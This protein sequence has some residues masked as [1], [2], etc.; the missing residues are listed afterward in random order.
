MSFTDIQNKIANA[1]PLDFGNLLN[2]SIEL[3]KKV[4]LQGLLMLLIMFAFIIPFVFIIYIPLLIFG[5]IDA[6]NPGQYNSLAPIAL[7]LVVVAYL[8]FVFIMIVISFG[9]KAGL[10]RIMR[11]KDLNEPG[12]EDYFYFLKKTYLSKTIYLSLAYF[13][14]T[15]LAFLLCFFPVIYVMIP[16]NLLVVMYAF[17][18]NISSSN[19]IKASF[20]LGNRKW[21]ITF[22]ITLVAGWLAQIV[23]VLMCGVGIFATASFAVIP[24]YLIYKD[25]FGFN[26]NTGEVKLIGNNEDFDATIL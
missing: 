7:L 13:G 16:L 4:W 20:E 9:L 8:I 23:G 1:K 11:Q 21:L 24:L 25:V 19:L 15:L 6:T 5:I 3:F 17:N 12:V 2:N 26:Q 22:G 18:P 10:F 14:I